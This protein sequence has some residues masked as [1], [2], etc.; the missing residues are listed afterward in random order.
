MPAVACGL[1]L[2]ILAICV[3]DFSITGGDDLANI[4]HAAVAHFDG[5]AVQDFVEW[6]FRGKA[7]V[8]NGQEFFA[9]I[10]CYIAAVGW[11]EPSYFSF[12]LPFVFLFMHAIVLVLGVKLEGVLVSTI[13]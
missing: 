5:I 9:D 4:G 8:D 1:R 12:A 3:H 11:V 2:I 6:V 13:A 10:G 7:L